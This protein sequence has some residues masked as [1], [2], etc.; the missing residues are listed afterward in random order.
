MNGG[1]RLAKACHEAGISL[2]TYRRWYRAGVIQAD[3]RPEVIKPAPANK[4]SEQE[5]QQILELCN[6]APYTSLP[7][8]QIVPDLMDKGLYVASEATF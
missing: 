3:Q 6:S 4:L 5:Q 8:S 2:R 7:P 1:A